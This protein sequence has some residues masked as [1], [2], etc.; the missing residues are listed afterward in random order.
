MGRGDSAVPFNQRRDDGP[1]GYRTEDEPID[2]RPLLLQTQFWASE[3]EREAYERAVQEIQPDRR[4]HAPRPAADASREERARFAGEAW[5]GMGELCRE[6][7]TL[8][9]G[10]C[11]RRNVRR[12][13]RRMGQREWSARQTDAKMRAAGDD[14]R[15]E[16]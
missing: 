14:W 9:E 10:F 11:P 5:M 2:D 4:F 12:M 3:E 13:P 7:A 1:R 15:G 8:A 6:I 16:R